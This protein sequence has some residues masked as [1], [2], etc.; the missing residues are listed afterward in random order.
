MK[1]KTICA[2]CGELISERYCP[3]TKNYQV[4]AKNG[5]MV[6]HGLC[7]ACRLAIE[8]KYGLNKNRGSEDV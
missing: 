7:P 8:A 5:E 4:L 3:E 6:S 2:W 1:I